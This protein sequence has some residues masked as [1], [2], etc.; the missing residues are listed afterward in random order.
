MKVIFFDIDGALNCGATA[1]PRHFPYVADKRPVRRFRALLTR[2]GAKP[3]RASS[4]RVDPIGPCAAKHF[5][6]PFFDVLPDRPRRAR[7]DEVLRWLAAHSRV[8]RFAVIDDDDELDA[9]PLFQPSP[10]TGLSPD[11]TRGVRSSFQENPTR[12]CG[13]ASSSALPKTRWRSFSATRISPF[14]GAERSGAAL[15][16]DGAGFASKTDARSA[17]NLTCVNRRAHARTPSSNQKDRP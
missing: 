16:G 12:R 4:W 10:R 1:N 6:I 3:S 9:L 13:R 2:T 17:K 15:V 5:G 14:G 7:R 11:I 8:T